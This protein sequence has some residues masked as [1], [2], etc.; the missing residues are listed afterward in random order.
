MKSLGCIAVLG[1][2]ASMAWGQNLV[3][4]ESVRWERN[5]VPVETFQEDRMVDVASH[6]GGL[7]FGDNKV[8]EAEYLF[9]PSFDGALGVRLVQDGIGARLEAQRVVNWKE[10]NERMNR[11]VRPT[12]VTNMT[13]EKW[14]QQKA[15]AEKARIARQ[16]E[17]SE[18]LQVESCSYPISDSMAGLF[19]A[20]I[21]RAVRSIEPDQGLD[22]TVRQSSAEMIADGDE[23]VFRRVVD[24][25]LCTLRY[26]VPEGAWADLSDLLRRMVGDMMQQSFDEAVYYSALAE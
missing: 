2:I 17:W 1:A 7:L 18:S 21:D 12:P 19:A 20:C 11:D 16:K 9:L 22:E 23:A 4:V 3:P 26:H 15:E 13:V 10:V 8:A 5:S 6:G 24:D 25:R 14:E